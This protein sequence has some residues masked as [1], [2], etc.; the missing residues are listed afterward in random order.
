MSV[1]HKISAEAIEKLKELAEGIDFCMFCTG[2]DQ[3]PI[4]VSPM[5]VQEVDEK[6]NIWFLASKESDK[7]KNIS[8]DSKVQLMFSDGGSFKFLSVFGKANISTD[9][10]RIDK[11]WNK[12]MEA[13][14]DKG[15]Q[16]PNIILIEV[17][18]EESYYWDTKN[19]KMV[20]MAKMLVAAVTG[21]SMDTGVEG[22]IEI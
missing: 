22:N 8:A 5:S 17:S 6:G 18:P 12:M 21:K 11:Y 3:R 1:D 14:F 19:S 2:L 7:Y 20:S 13:W 9:Q 15:R 4:E 10:V 16:D